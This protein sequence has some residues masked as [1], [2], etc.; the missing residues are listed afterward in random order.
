[1]DKNKIAKNLI[2]KIMMVCVCLF[3]LGSGVA[4]A[5]ADNVLRVGIP[6]DP[7][8]LAP[9]DNVSLN[10]KAVV[11]QICETLLWLDENG[12]IKPRLA[13]SWEFPDDKSIMFHIRKGVKFHDG[14]V[15]DAD[16]VKFSLERIKQEKLKAS[17]MLTY[18]EKVEVIDTY[19][20]KV[21]VNTISSVAVY[22]FALSGWIESPSAI[23]KYGKEA[24][25]H[26]VGTG[27]FKFVEW[28]AHEKI[29]LAP[30][31]EYWAGTPFLSKVELKPVPE[32]QTRIAM[33]E[34]G[35]L[36]VVMTP[37]LTS[38]Q[39]LEGKPGIKVLSANGNLVTYICFNLVRS[40]MD[41][42]KVRQAIAHAINREG[43]VKA[44][45]FGKA[46]TADSFVSPDL[47]YS[48]KYDLYPYNPEKAMNL[49]TDLG[50]KKGK[51]GMLEKDGKPFEISLMTPVGRYPMDAQI[52]QAV[53][54]QLK[55]IGIKVAVETLE[56]GAFV[57]FALS[58][59]EDKQAS[60]T[61][62]VVGAFGR[63][64]EIGT[65]LTNIW[66]SSSLI[67]N[68]YNM[69]FFENEKFDQAVNDAKNESDTAKRKVHLEKAQDILYDEIPMIP[70]YFW[71][72]L[73]FI[74][75]GVKGVGMPN[76]SN[77]FQIFWDAKVN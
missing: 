75:N 60:N 14:T 63:Y 32:A 57:K 64:A 53:Q 46:R 29:S 20:V 28:K 33:L 41:N 34:A 56:S 70:V 27:P 19:T 76:S 62:L 69:F 77:E 44:L 11:R 15:C 73:L 47:E 61:G 40:P 35:D 55:K 71:P 2:S 51:K 12:K 22:Q 31:K 36:D 4:L 7:N 42:K 37:P 18:L 43:I 65:A 30:F 25:L 1:M 59:K 58:K 24:G 45:L 72:N 48:K 5:K 10:A 17:T 50:W 67:P 6:G 16:A 39:S 13:S 74:K 52:A 66:H 26:P 3:I 54:A 68:G 38:L 23:K 8:S 9:N 21:H 49:L